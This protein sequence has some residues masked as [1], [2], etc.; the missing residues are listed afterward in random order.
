MYPLGVPCNDIHSSMCSLKICLIARYLWPV[1]WSTTHM[2]N[3]KKQ[4]SNFASKTGQLDWYSN[5]VDPYEISKI[6]IHNSLLATYA[7]RSANFPFLSVINSNYGAISHRYRDFRQMT[8]V[9][10]SKVTKGQTHNATRFATHDFLL[11]FY[12]NYSAISHGNPVFQQMTLIWPF[13][14]T[15][16]R[17]DNS[18]Q[19]ATYD[20]LLTFSGHSCMRGANATAS[21][22]VNNIR[23]TLP[24]S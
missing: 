10:S 11:T 2:K 5:N 9:W 24:P 3:K 19:S 15:K 1:M 23:C 7:I 18:I 13:K 16:G 4:D 12:S 14:V 8:L 17:T 6:K 21:T 22:H 20:F